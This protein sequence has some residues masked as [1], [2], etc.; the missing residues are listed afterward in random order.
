MARLSYGVDKVDVGITTNMP[1]RSVVW[2]S[3][4]NISFRPGIVMKNFGKELLATISGIPIRAKFTYKAYDNVWRTIVC[5]DNKIYSYT[6]NFTVQQDITPSTPPTSTYLDTWCFG[7]IGGMLIISNGVNQIWKWD[8]FSSKIVPLSESFITCKALAVVNNRLLIGNIQEGAYSFPARIRWSDIISANKWDKNLKLD[9][10]QVDIVSPDTS[11]DGIDV[12]QAITNIGS[13]ALVFTERNI[14]YLSDTVHPVIFTPEPLGQNIGLPGKRAYVKTPLGIFFL[15]QEDFYRITQAI[16]EPIGFRIRNSCFPNINKSRINTAFAYYKY[17]TREVVFC[18]PTGNNVLP[19]TGFVYGVETDSWSIWDVD[20]LCYSQ[21]FDSSN[22]TYDTLQYGSYD[23]ITDSRYD[24][25]GNT[26]LLPSDA[27]GNADGQIL[28]LDSGYNNNGQPINAYI[29]S[30]DF[31]FKDYQGNDL[32]DI[33]KIIYEV[34]PSLKPQEA[35]S[36][37]MIQVGVRDNLHQ[38]IAWSIPIAYNIGVSKNVNMRIQGKW[39]RVRYYTDTLNSP[40]ILDGWKIK[41]DKGSSR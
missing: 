34:W 39:I 36:S 33:N 20:Y 37:L 29:E 40:W 23:S 14:W 21:Y 25:I 31:L 5:S 28:R 26:G 17:S 35:M 30:G 13:R 27:V 9:S 8:N 32:V 19:D 12:I 6:N 2:S 3:G 38:D 24:D 1:S 11:M 7:V 22:I 41:F 10:G 15:G 16:P 18:V 4:R